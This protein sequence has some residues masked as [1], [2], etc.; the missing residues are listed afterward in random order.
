MYINSISGQPSHFPL[1]MKPEMVF[2]TLGFYP[3]LAWFVAQEKFIEFSLHE[4]FK[5]CRNVRTSGCL[6]ALCIFA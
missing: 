3:Q 1:V 2:Q 4:S 5:S 6:T